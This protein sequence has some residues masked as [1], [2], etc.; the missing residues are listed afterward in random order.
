MKNASV[1]SQSDALNFF[2]YIIIIIIIII[3]IKGISS[4]S[5]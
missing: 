3:I 2:M 1:F 5:R 4:I